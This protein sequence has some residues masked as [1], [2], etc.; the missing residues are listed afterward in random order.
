MSSKRPKLFMTILLFLGGFIGLLFGCVLALFIGKTL[1]IEKNTTAVTP[2]PNLAIRNVTVTIDPKLK[3]ELFTQLEN[4][5]DEWRYA[6]LIAPTNSNGNEYIVK[7]YRVDM[8]MTGSY[9][10]DTGVLEL[11]FYNTRAVG[12]NPERYFD[13]ELKDL[14]S[15]ISEIPNS[16]YSVK[17]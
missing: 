12:Q 2:I 7:L 9:Y 17:K 5:A 10:A 13:D 16:S 15:L 14:K 8:K 11:G 1:P 6:V 4:F 3:D